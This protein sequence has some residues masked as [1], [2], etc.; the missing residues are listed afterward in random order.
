MKKGTLLPAKMALARW[1]A[2]VQSSGGSV[3]GEVSVTDVGDDPIVVEPPIDLER[4]TVLAGRYQVETYVGKGGSG[5]VLRAFDR[6]TQ[7]PV[8]LKVLSQELA[9]DPHWG[10]RF[11]R[12]LRLGRQIQHPNVCRVFD[13]GESD[14]H[15]FLSMELATKGTLRAAVRADA[16]PRPFAEKVADARALVSGLAALHAAGIIHRDVKPENLLRM[17]DGRIVLSD[18]GL[19]TNPAQ[20]AAVTV[21]VGTPSYMAPEIVMGDP[22]SFRSDVWALGVTM[23]EILFGKRPEWDVVDGE[24]KLRMPL[25]KCASRLERTLAEVC[26]GCAAE[27]ADQRPA[28]AI[29]VMILLTP[30][31]ESSPRMPARRTAK[32]R[33]EGRGWSVMAVVVAAVGAIAIAKGNLF[34]GA[35]ATLTPNARVRTVVPEGVP[36][37]WSKSRMLAEFSGRVHC[38]AASHDGRSAQVIWGSPRV[39]E[40]VDATT[41][42]RSPSDLLPETFQDGCPD[43]SPQGEKLLFA[44]VDS[45]GAMQVMLSDQPNGASAKAITRGTSPEWLAN[46]TEFLYNLDGTHAAVFHLPTTMFSLVDDSTSGSVGFIQGMVVNETKNAFAIKRADEYENVSVSIFSWPGAA[47]NVTYGLPKGSLQIAFSPIS[48]RLLFSV[49]ASPSSSHLAELNWASGEASKLGAVS[50]SDVRGLIR[51]VSGQGLILSR[52][53]S[54]DV[55]LVEPDGAHHSF[56]NDGENWSTDRTASG[57]VAVGKRNAD[58]GMVAVGYDSSGR[59]LF[60][61]QGPNDRTPSFS[62]DGKTFVFVRLSTKAIVLC[63]GDSTNCHEVRTE[64]LLP[65]WSRLAPDGR[66][67]AYVTQIGVPRVHVISTD[68]Q[69]DRDLGPARADC[70]SIWTAADR[71]WIYQGSDRERHWAEFDLA[72]GHLTGREKKAPPIG[73]PNE[74]WRDTEEWSSP[75]FGRARIVKAENSSVRVLS[76]M[77]H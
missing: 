68:G 65:V 74:C 23:H 42:H 44:A 24:R 27:H 7:A 32:S 37:D 12:E 26:A 67:I 16:P 13:I 25:G 29:D 73:G 35:W 52:R 63:L 2:S 20:T 77:T 64:N 69:S 10:E 21:L 76:G 1:V 5:V 43:L 47:P 59:A 38:F 39:A 70:P 9:S 60:S 55:W 54:G 36:E 40:N 4:G 31:R 41:G 22:A 62:E 46:G 14:G 57:Y 61:S 58:G 11:S 71:L 18:F 72:A 8:A 50:G 34:S 45:S 15:R 3:A 6:I 53:I 30:G 28:N 19:A 56:T 48:Q 75:F 66:S 49:E 51:G 17:E 33:G